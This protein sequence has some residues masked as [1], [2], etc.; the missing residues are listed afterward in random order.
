[1][2]ILGT[3]T[4]EEGGHTLEESFARTRTWKMQADALL[5]LLDLRG[6]FAEGEDE[7]G[8]L[9]LGQRRVLEGVCT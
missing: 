6:D 8:R 9:G 3:G 2:F 4:R 1:M 7:R 5:V